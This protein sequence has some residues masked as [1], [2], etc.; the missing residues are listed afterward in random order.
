MSG[1]A[2]MEEVEPKVQKIMKVQSKKSRID[3]HL[4][5]IERGV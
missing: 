4:L 2:I 5:L 3:L 1:L